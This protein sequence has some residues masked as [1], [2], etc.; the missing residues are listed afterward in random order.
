M[1]A[2]VPAT[3]SGISSSIIIATYNGR[4]LAAGTC[5][6][7]YAGLITYMAPTT[8]PAVPYLV[9]GSGTNILSFLRSGQNVL[10]Y[11]PGM[12]TLNIE[13]LRSA[14]ANGDYFASQFAP[15]YSDRVN[16]SFSRQSPNGIFTFYNYF[17]QAAD[18]AGSINASTPSVQTSQNALTISGWIYSRSSCS[19]VG[20]VGQGSGGANNWELKT[21]WDGGSW[22][23][24]ASQ[25]SCPFG[26]VNSYIWQFIT[27][28][29]SNPSGGSGNAYLYVNGTLTATNTVSGL[30]NTGVPL[31]FGASPNLSDNYFDGL[32]SD[33]QLYNSALNSQQVQRLYQEGLGGIPLSS[34]NIVGWWPLNGN[35]NDYSGSGNNANPSGVVTYREAANYTRDGIFAV[36]VPTRTI[37]F[38]GLQSCNNNAQC[39]S[40]SLPHIYLGYS[41]LEIKNINLQAGNFNGTSSYVDAGNGGSLSPISFVTMSAWVR[42][43]PLQNAFSHII[44][45]GTVSGQPTDGYTLRLANGDPSI[46]FYDGT[47]FHQASSSTAITDNNWHFVAGTYDGSYLKVYVDGATVAN[48]PASGSINPS[49]VDLY[50]GT[51]AAASGYTFNGQIADVQIYGMPL[52]NAQ[53]QQLYQEGIAGVPIS[54]S[55]LVGWWPLNGNATDYSGMGGSGM[56]KNVIYPYIYYSRERTTHPAC[57]HC[58][59]SQANGR[60]WAS[61]AGRKRDRGRAWEGAANDLPIHRAAQRPSFY[62]LLCG[63]CRACANRRKDLPPIAAE[64]TKNTTSPYQ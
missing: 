51:S 4:N 21:S 39:A 50:L 3:L 14:I 16:N 62:F 2:P 64:T 35:F 37:P 22:N 17:T 19:C 56:P 46:G 42:A 27:A 58:P 34:A 53:V 30:L 38:P 43:S 5:I 24:I 25:K 59:Q 63:L 36:T 32:L 47:A 61:Q 11:G 52:S 20:V 49:S 10:L 28:V 9:Y 45:K 48:T 60:R 41:P 33:V 6:S 13:S 44:S 40:N 12:D 54:G 23:F 26:T 15:T 7:N 57:L 8:A 29:Y 55:G 18:F 31:Y 1:P